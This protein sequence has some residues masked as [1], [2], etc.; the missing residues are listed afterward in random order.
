MCQQIITLPYRN[1]KAELEKR[2]R[3]IDY[4][5][6]HCGSF[7][8]MPWAQMTTEDLEQLSDGIALLVFN[9]EMGR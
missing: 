2:Q 3:L 7:K 6:G 4:I 8:A 9:R 1:T 5:E